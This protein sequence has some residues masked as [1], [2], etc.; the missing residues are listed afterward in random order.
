MQLLDLGSECLGLPAGRVALGSDFAIRR[1][2]FGQVAPQLI[3]GLDEDL[4]FATSRVAVGTDIP[5][6]A[7]QLVAQISN[8]LF[9]RASFPRRLVS[10]Y[11]HLAKKLGGGL[12]SCPLR[13]DRLACISKGIVQCGRSRTLNLKLTSQ[14]P[15]LA[16]HRITLRLDVLE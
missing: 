7:R 4:E 9:E 14:S 2:T 10:L 15:D 11:F 8:F 16:S 1:S 13:R 5:E 6:S 3:Y 12:P